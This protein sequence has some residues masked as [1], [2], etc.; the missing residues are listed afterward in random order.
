MRLAFHPVVVE[1]KENPFGFELGK[2]E[3]AA[4]KT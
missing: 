1:V 3:G 4:N 2:T